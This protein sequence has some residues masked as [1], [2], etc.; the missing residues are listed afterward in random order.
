MDY[1][2]RT[3]RPTCRCKFGSNV[4]SKPDR[5]RPEAPNP[6]EEA[7]NRRYE[8]K[9]NP[10]SRTQNRII[11]HS[12]SKS[13][14]LQ[15]ALPPRPERPPRPHSVIS[16]QNH[17][18]LKKIKDG[19]FTDIEIHSQKYGKLMATHVNT[20]SKQKSASTTNLHIYNQHIDIEPN[21]VIQ[22]FLD[23]RE[24][25]NKKYGIKIAPAKLLKK[26]KILSQSLPIMITYIDDYR[27]SSFL[28]DSETLEVPREIRR[29]VSYSNCDSSS[30]S[31]YNSYSSKIYE[32][33]ISACESGTTDS[34]I[35]RQKK[36]NKHTKQS[37]PA[38]Q[39]IRH[40]T[41]IKNVNIYQN[42]GHSAEP[43][44]SSNQK[45]Y[46]KK[47]WS[48]I[49]H[50]KYTR[51]DKHNG[52]RNRSKSR[53]KNKENANKNRNKKRFEIEIERKNNND[54]TKPNSKVLRKES[55]DNFY[56]K[57]SKNIVTNVISPHFQDTDSKL[58]QDEQVSQSQESYQDENDQDFNENFSQ[59]EI[60]INNSQKQKPGQNML[61]HLQ[62][63]I[64]QEES[65]NRSSSSLHDK[66][67]CIVS[68][69]GNKN[70][71]NRGVD[72]YFDR[73]DGIL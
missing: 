4:Y 34:G 70:L 8:R 53:G 22:K 57:N 26:S 27:T 51:S 38:K 25:D 10:N 72:D 12:K 63:P 2:G 6:F 14:N 55:I 15:S 28:S 18:F 17:E 60:P 21:H 52:K 41:P 73:W 49:D 23:P 44:L 20:K 46:H 61:Q 66:Y 68:D 35:Q 45:S 16:A 59:Y 3:K 71:K 54:D 42:R 67:K 30:S 43:Y 36:Q 69:S 9:D 47:H 32:N 33:S 39:K 13:Y 31:Y 37:K 62:K 48:E 56:G 65:D 1:Q 29:S 50:N 19:K 58:Y 40:S 64:K 11:K 24:Y 5:C 7:T